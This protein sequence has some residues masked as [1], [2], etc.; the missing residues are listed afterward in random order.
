[1]EQKNSINYQIA[2]DLE[3]K[4]SAAA[5]KYRT[6]N[7]LRKEGDELGFGELEV[8]MR[9]QHRKT[10]AGDGIR[11]WDGEIVAGN[12]I[13]CGDYGWGWRKIRFRVWRKED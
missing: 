13:R 11:I 4:E 12:G 2:A 9:D 5:E 8:G 6:Q 10:V 1:M 3:K 7:C